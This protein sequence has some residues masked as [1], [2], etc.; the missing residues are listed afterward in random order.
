M[1]IFS[2]VSFFIDKIVSYII[3]IALNINVNICDKNVCH[4]ISFVVALNVNFD[5][6]F[7]KIYSRDLQNV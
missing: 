3:E 2:I 7:F 6:N 5:I 1:I 4:N